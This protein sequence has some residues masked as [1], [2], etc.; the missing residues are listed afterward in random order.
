M[1]VANSE[2]KGALLY[3]N[4][5]LQNVTN[6]T[7]SNLIPENYHLKIQKEGYT[8]WEKDIKVEENVVI[9]IDARLFPMNP[10]LTPVTL[11]G[12]YNPQVNLDNTKIVFQVRDNEEKNGVW[13]LVFNNLP[14]GKGYDLKQILKDT[15]N[16]KYSQAESLWSQDGNELLVSIQNDN[17]TENYIVTNDILSTSVTKS[18]KTKEEIIMKWKIEA[19]SLTKD[20]ISTLSLNT[21]GI[22]KDK[23]IFWSPDQNKFYYENRDGFVEVYDLEKET[24]T[25]STI[26][27][28][29]YQSVIWFID[30]ERFIFVENNEETKSGKLSITEIDGQNKVSVYEGILI[31]KEVFVSPNGNKLFFL[32]NFNPSSS[33][34][35]NL[36]TLNLD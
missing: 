4:D 33:T 30:S 28:S 25:T 23:T 29:D 12:C 34:S 31:S 10:S 24:I 21:Q 17:I 5:Q 3:L 18:T 35:T 36:Y 16:I 6:T 1:I 27:I 14:F 2:P 19:D 7:L 32:T 22:I 11:Y 8:S 20:K 15:A 9:Q 26:K 13:L